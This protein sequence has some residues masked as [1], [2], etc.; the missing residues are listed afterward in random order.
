MVRTPNLR[1]SGWLTGRFPFMLLQLQGSLVCLSICNTLLFVRTEVGF[2]SLPE[3]HF[4]APQGRGLPG[5]IESEHFSWNLLIVCSGP[6][7][8]H[9]RKVQ[10]VAFFCP[11]RVHPSLRFSIS[12]LCEQVLFSPT[13]PSPRS[14]A[15]L[16]VCLSSGSHISALPR[17]P[18]SSRDVIINVCIK[19]RWRTGHLIITQLIGQR[20][21]HVVGHII[22]R[23]A[24]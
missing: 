10:C 7:S 6:A 18:L 12:T 8:L 2:N 22:V 14:A 17:P 13:P 5:S 15:T 16:S 9:M 23:V 11:L 4:K 21:T 19:G 1:L 24:F 3:V 20:C